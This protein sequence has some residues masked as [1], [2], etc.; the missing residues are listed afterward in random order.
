MHDV[1]KHVLCQKHKFTEK[2]KYSLKSVETHIKLFVKLS[3]IILFIIH[4]II[5]YYLTIICYKF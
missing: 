2:G 3:W 4:A 5:I 1:L